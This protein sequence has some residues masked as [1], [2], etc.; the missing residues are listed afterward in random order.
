MEKDGFVVVRDV[1]PSEMIAASRDAC[2]ELFARTMRAAGGS[3]G[4]GTREGY[5][6]VV[7]RHRGRFEIRVGDEL[8]ALRSHLMKSEAYRVATEALGGNVRV[9]ST[10]CI[11]A[12]NGCEGQAWHSDG[13][14]LDLD[15]HLP[16]H[17][18]NL[19][20]PLVDISQG[21]GTEV[22]PGSHFVT[23]DLKK[24]FFIARARKLIGPPLAP[25]LALG[26][27]LIFDYRT[28]HRGRPNLTGADRPVFVLTLARPPYT[29]DLLNFPSRSL[30]S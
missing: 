20:V 5:Y 23:R 9:V 15:T 19:F 11:V 21:S 16:C 30:S 8:G 7:Q 14:H 13:P 25:S 1:V 24:L 22:R 10:T 4:I 17:C 2:L 26:D 29:R 12:T 27:C 18:L 6:E 3:M 28:L